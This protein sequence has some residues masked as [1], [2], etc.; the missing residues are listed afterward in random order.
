MTEQRIV[1]REEGQTRSCSRPPATGDHDAYVGRTVASLPVLP[2]S[3]S[4][5]TLLLLPVRNAL[6]AALRSPGPSTTPPCA[7]LG[8]MLPSCIWICI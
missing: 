3:S 2:S 6:L 1:E 5:H 8:C 4:S 7:L